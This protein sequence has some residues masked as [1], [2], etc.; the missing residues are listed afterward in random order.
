MFSCNSIFVEYSQPQ[1]QLICINCIRID[2]GQSENPCDIKEVTKCLA[3]RSVVPSVISLRVGSTTTFTSGTS[4][5]SN[6]SLSS[7]CGW[8]YN[9][10]VSQLSEHS[11]TV[12][13][14]AVTWSL[15]YASLGRPVFSC[16]RKMMMTMVVAAFLP[17]LVFIADQQRW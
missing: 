1:S 16:W 5:K 15:E 13:H 11:D 3:A 9:S 12:W 8:D 2:C 7:V 17:S 10:G 6:M 4:K 14:E